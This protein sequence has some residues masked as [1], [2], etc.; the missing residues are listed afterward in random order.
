MRRLALGVAIVVVAL[1]IGATP[2][3]AQG[4]GV[5]IAA[6]QSLRP[7]TCDGDQFALGVVFTGVL[8]AGNRT[9]VGSFSTRVVGPYTNDPCPP[10]TG[11]SATL[12][13]A[14]PLD[15]EGV[16]G[17][18]AGT[19]GGSESD[20]FQAA[21]IIGQRA[22]S[23][24][25]GVLHLACQVSINGGPAV[26]IVIDATLLGSLVGGSNLVQVGSYTIR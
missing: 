23:P 10:G 11:L 26:T 16:G 25:R 2:A 13:S 6:A 8:A 7:L 1:G 20:T 21:P 14:G 3:Q 9:Y 18:L 15:G 17:K 22:D 5:G 12:S 24:H 4:S 19:C